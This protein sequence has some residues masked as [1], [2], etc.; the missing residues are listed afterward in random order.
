ME[1][2]A[3]RQPLRPGEQAKRGRYPGTAMQ[4]A[5]IAAIVLVIAFAAVSIH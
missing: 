3:K 2:G 1:Q 4:Y 5:V